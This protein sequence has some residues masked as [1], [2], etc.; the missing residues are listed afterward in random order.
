VAHFKTMLTNTRE[1]QG[2]D[3]MV[4]FVLILR[5][6]SQIGQSAKAEPDPHK[7]RS[8]SCTRTNDRCTAIRS[9][10]WLPGDNPPVTNQALPPRWLLTDFN[11]DTSFQTRVRSIWSIGQ[12]RHKHEPRRPSHGVCA[13]R[14]NYRSPNG[15]R[16]QYQN[17]RK[18]HL[19]YGISD[20]RRPNPFAGIALRIFMR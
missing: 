2:F 10:R 12:R 8:G 16:F 6:D 3:E 5:I 18:I 17:A 1:T 9:R 20:D 11:I 19:R 7:S 4:R 13:T 15:D 14:Y